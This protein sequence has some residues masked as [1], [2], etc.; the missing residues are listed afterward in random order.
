MKNASFSAFLLKWKR[1]SDAFSLETLC[2]WGLSAHWGETYSI[3]EFLCM[4]WNT[5]IAAHVCYKPGVCCLL[6]RVQNTN[7]TRH[8]TFSLQHIHLSD[9]CRVWPVTAPQ[10]EHHNSYRRGEPN[11]DTYGRLL[12]MS[13]SAQWGWN[14]IPLLW[15]QLAA[16]SSCARTHTC[17]HT[18][19]SHTNN[20][21]SMSA[22]M[23]SMRPHDCCD[24][25][26]WRSTDEWWGLICVRWTL[27]AAPL[28]GDR[29]H[30][31]VSNWR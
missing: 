29:E 25:K 2:I 26:S 17:A 8:E 20:C 10:T 19:P 18:S 22:G 11:S 24:M 30:V 21:H 1:K 7:N 28:T 4:A 27:K 15:W 6:I 12:E 3:N 31:R 14:T 23:K 13:H 5:C 16:A 9:W